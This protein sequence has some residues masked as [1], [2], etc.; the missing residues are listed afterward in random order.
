MVFLIWNKQ[1]KMKPMPLTADNARPLNNNKRGVENNRIS[2]KISKRPRNELFYQRFRTI[3]CSKRNLSVQFGKRDFH[4]LQGST[5]GLSANHSNNIM[6]SRITCW[7]N[8]IS[9]FNFKNSPL[10]GKDIVLLAFYLDCV[11]AKP[12]APRILTNCLLSPQWT[13]FW[14]VY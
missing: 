8:K 12:Y 5:V 7:V 11:R 13:K 1:R 6:Y 3:R 10:P 2:L 9:L 4:R 14:K